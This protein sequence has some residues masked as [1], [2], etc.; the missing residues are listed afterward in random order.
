[1]VP[2][3]SGTKAAPEAAGRLLNWH[4]FGHDHPQSVPVALLIVQAGEFG[5]VLYSAAVT[6]RVMQPDHASILA[7]IVVISIALNPFF[8]RL[9]GRLSGEAKKGQC[10]KKIS[11]MSTQRYSWSV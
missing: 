8:Y 7:A 2:T 6:A 5:F 10:L 9:C 3:A 11:W 4:I 1:M